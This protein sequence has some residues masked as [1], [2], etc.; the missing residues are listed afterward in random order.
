MDCFTKQS[1]LSQDQLKAAEADMM[2]L[3]EKQGDRGKEKK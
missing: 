2:V 1:P 3:L